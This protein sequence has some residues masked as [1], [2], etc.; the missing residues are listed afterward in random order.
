M[1]QL[2]SPLSKV[3]IVALS[4]GLTW[5]TVGTVTESFQHAAAEQAVVQLPRVVVVG[6]RTD[7]LVPTAKVAKKQQLPDGAK[8][9]KMN[10]D[11]NAAI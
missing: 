11:K 9:T 4:A 3:V 7:R 6:Q 8:L 2:V 10:A 1:F 5:S